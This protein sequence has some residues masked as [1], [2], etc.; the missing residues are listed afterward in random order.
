MSGFSLDLVHLTESYAL[1]LGT[2][3]KSIKT[4]TWY[5]AN[6]NRFIQF[7]D[8]NS[9]S[10]SIT[11]IGKEEVRKFITHLQNDVIRWEDCPSIHDDKRLSAYSIQ[12]YVR[13]IKAF[14]S[15]LLN[16]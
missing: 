15:W 2:E 9:L 12:G 3:G 7:L 6:L 10:T 1:C 14:W 11:D 8:E 5:T 13:K 16:E 4:I